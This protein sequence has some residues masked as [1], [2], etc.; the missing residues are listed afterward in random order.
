ML[1]CWTNAGAGSALAAGKTLAS[2][3]AA[4]LFF[5]GRASADRQAST[6]LTDPAPSDP[7]HSS[8][9]A[10]ARTVD[11][12]SSSYQAQDLIEEMA[13]DEKPTDITESAP[14]PEAP[15]QR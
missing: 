2:R 5:T 12:S 15:R 8:K 14:A 10:Q 13:D 7:A 1:D 4:N 3:Q 6:D 11:S 9:L